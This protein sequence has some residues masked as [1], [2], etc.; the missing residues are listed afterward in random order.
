MGRSKDFD[1]K[2]ATVA[3]V[4]EGEREFGR[5]RQGSL[6][7][8]GRSMIEPYRGEFNARFTAEKYAELLR[9]LDER[10]GGSAGLV[11]GQSV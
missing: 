5:V 8:V 11:L 1:A 3:K 4:R 6:R 2:G 9:V 10:V 7:R